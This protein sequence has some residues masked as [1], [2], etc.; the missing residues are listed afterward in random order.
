M[1]Y[2]LI[3]HLDRQRAFSAK[4]FGPGDRAAGVRDHIRKELDEIQ[5]E[6]VGKRLEEWIDVIL[7]ACDGAWRDGHTSEEITEALIDKLARNELRDWPDWRTVPADKAI[8]HVRPDP[9]R[10]N[11]IVGFMSEAQAERLLEEL[12]S[13]KSR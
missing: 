10:K 8:E 12:R 2:D 6:P 7:L 5:A 13:E 9:L 4:T 3:A 11:P 1:P